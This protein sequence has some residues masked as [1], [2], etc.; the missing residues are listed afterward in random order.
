MSLTTTEITAMSSATTT[1]IVTLIPAT[2]TSG[3]ILQLLYNFFKHKLT[4]FQNVICLIMTTLTY[5]F[6]ILLI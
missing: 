2:A 4:S 3:H 5:L 6:Y 1:T